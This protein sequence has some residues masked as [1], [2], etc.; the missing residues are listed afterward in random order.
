VGER[1]KRAQ[2][3]SLRFQWVTWLGWLTEGGAVRFGAFS[4]S[5]REKKAYISPS[6]KEKIATVMKIETAESL[7]G[8]NRGTSIRL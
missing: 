8:L 3:A 4:P 6:E 1:E 2:G 7:R 5:W